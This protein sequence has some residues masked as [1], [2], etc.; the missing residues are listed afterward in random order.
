VNSGIIGGGT[1]HTSLLEVHI[2]KHMS[3]IKFEVLDVP[4]GKEQLYMDFLPMTWLVQHNP[5][6][7]WKNRSMKWRSQYCKDNCH[8]KMI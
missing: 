6:I 1:H 3:D 8:P 2:G 5:D 4:C 7:D